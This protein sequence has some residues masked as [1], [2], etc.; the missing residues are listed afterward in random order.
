MFDWLKKAK[1]TINQ[2]DMLERIKNTT[3][4]DDE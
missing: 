2:P 4:K 3:L 1:E